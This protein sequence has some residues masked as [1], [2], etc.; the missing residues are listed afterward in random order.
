PSLGGIQNLVLRNV[1]GV[2]DASVETI[3]SYR[4]H[5]FY[6]LDVA[7]TRLSAAS[8]LKLVKT[9]PQLYYL[10]IDADQFSPELVELIRSKP[11]LTRVGIVGGTDEQ[12]RQLL[13]V[14]HLT[15]LIEIWQI[16]PATCRELAT[17]LPN[18]DFVIGKGLS[19]DRAAA[20]ASGPKLAQLDMS[21]SPQLTDTGLKA[22]HARGSLRRLVVYRCPKVTK[23]AVEALH[24]AL[25]LCRIESDH[26]TFE[27]ASVGKTPQP[28]AK[29]ELSYLR[30]LEGHTDQV[31]SVAFTP[32]GKGLL[33]GSKDK[34]MRL[35]D[36]ET[37]AQR[38]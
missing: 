32:D 15:N 35:W 27:P 38:K 1:K 37:G 13:S 5:V 22:L 14:A 17:R 19:D 31:W 29:T 24:K 36:V 12:W 20:F 21:D 33:T 30:T 6:A 8:C 7:G 23:P 26:G 2:T 28:A 16:S 9:L 11:G 18:L 10:V 34:T 25:P 3:L 4:N